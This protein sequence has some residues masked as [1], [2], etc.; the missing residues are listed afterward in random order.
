MF[1]AILFPGQTFPPHCATSNGNQ[2]V[3]DSDSGSFFSQVAG[4]SPSNR[5][6]KLIINALRRAIWRRQPAQ[7]LIFHSEA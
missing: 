6:K 7:G 3:S 2:V 5:M 1:I 4:W